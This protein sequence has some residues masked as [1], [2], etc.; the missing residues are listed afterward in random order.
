MTFPSVGNDSA[1]ASDIPPRTPANY[2]SK[3]SL[4]ELADSCL[5]SSVIGIK[6]LIN[7]AA[8]TINMPA[9]PTKIAS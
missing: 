1:N 7:L 6:M 8:V 5:S 3:L 4:A 9:I 2:N